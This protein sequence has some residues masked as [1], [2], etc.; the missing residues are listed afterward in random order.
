MATD[1]LAFLTDRVFLLRYFLLLLLTIAG[2]Y[3]ARML[4]ARQDQLGALKSELEQQQ[5][6]LA[7]KT[8]VLQQ[9]ATDLG[10]RVLELRS[11]QEVARALSSTLE[12]EAVLQLIVDRLTAL[13]GT[14]HCAVALL[15]EEQG[16][17]VG[18]VASVGG[19]GSAQTQTAARSFTL[20]LAEEPASARAIAER[21]P[22]VVTD[23]RASL[24]A[25]QRHLGQLWGIRTYLVMPLVVRQRAIGALYLADTRPGFRF[26]EKQLQ[27]TA[28]FAYFAAT[29]IE[30]ARLYQEAWEKSRE[31]EAILASIGDGVIVADP[32]LNLL[33]MN[34]VAAR[35]CGLESNLPAGVPLSLLIPG[36]PLVDLLRETLASDAPLI[37]EIELSPT[38][39]GRS[40]IY[41]ALASPVPAADRNARGVVTVLRDI[42][43]QKELERMK[44]N[45]LSVVSH[46]LKTPLHSIKGFVEI[47]L[48][49]KT[50]PVGELQRDFLSTV[51][52]QTNHLQRLIDDLLEFSRLEAG[53][54]RLRLELVQPAQVAETVVEKLTPLAEEKGIEL[55]NEIEGQLPVIEAD[56]M[57]LEQVLTN[58]VDNAIKFTPVGGR[59]TVGG[60]PRNGN[61][62][63]MWVRDT[64]I[65]IPLEE[66]ERIF[67]RFYQVDS[68]TSRAY[69]GTGLGLTIC[70]HIVA[71]HGGRIWVESDGHPGSGATFRFTLPRRHPGDRKAALDFTALP[72]RGRGL[73]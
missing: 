54:V 69:K 23:A 36:N 50:G 12:V 72:E 33:L 13:V 3:F 62:V 44:S 21:R 34:P 68:S 56:R 25:G 8:Q 59:V 38:P 51:K 49:G 55:R 26:G 17:L 35:I 57:R 7:Q 43:G 53:Q 39:E 42:T 29:A 60:R 1:S 63:E 37:Q 24:H 45:F 22:T 67:D 16:R 5:A 70:K 2:W 40:R 30:N 47:I 52:Q 46:E 6:V 61:E 15:E 10:D 31:L 64:G 65:G 19:E 27:L 9:T 14:S 58:L 41:Q 71:H 18:T 28:S 73:H 4:A 32:E 11:L 20:S 48:M 66:Q